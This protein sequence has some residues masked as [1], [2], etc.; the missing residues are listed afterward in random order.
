M[1]EVLADL[2]TLYDEA[3]TQDKLFI[4]TYTEWGRNELLK[5]WKR[6][7]AMHTEPELTFHD[8]R[9]VAIRWL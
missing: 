2:R 4:F 7:S 8:L 6:I 1:P 5:A 3:Q 9:K